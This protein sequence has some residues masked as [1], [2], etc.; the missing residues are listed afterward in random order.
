MKPIAVA[1]AAFGSYPGSVVVDFTSLA[2]RGL[3]VVTG[4]TGTGKSTIFDA[5]SFALFGKMPS[6]DGGD[7][8]SH[9]ATSSIDTFAKFT[10]EVDGVEY[11]AER[12]PSYLRPKK[13][14]HGATPQSASQLLTRRESDGSTTTLATK[15]REFDAHIDEII[16]LDAEQFRRVMLL[17]QGEVAR[18]L[19]DDS[20]QREELLSQLFG[21]A[22]YERVVKELKSTSD[23]LAQQVGTVDEQLRH[24]LANARDQLHELYTQLGVEAPELADHPRDGLDDVLAGVNSE[25]AQLDTDATQADNNATTAQRHSDEA[26]AAAHRFDDA[27]RHRTTLARLEADEPEVVAAASAAATSRSARPVVTAQARL[28]E[29]IASE[30]AAQ[31]DLNA[32]TE[33]IVDI[34]ASAGIE[35]GDLTAI[36]VSRQH[37]ALRSRLDIDRAALA[38][39]ADAATEANQ[40]VQAVLEN[41]RIQLET[42]ERMAAIAL[43]IETHEQRLAVLAELAPDTSAIDTE[44]ERL[45][46]A[47]TAIIERDAAASHRVAALAAATHADTEFDTTLERYVATEAPRLAERLTPGGPCMVCGSL[48]HPAPATADGGTVVSIDEVNSARE[49]R[50]AARHDADEADRR[51]AALTASLGDLAETS[52]GELD[53]RIADN[54]SEYAATN[55]AIAERRQLALRIEQLNKDLVDTTTA[56]HRAAG[57]QPGLIATRD[58]TA[59]AL[60]AAQAEADAIDVAQLEVVSRS[61]DE[62]EQLITGLDDLYTTLTSAQSRR[63]SAEGVLH[64]ALSKSPFESVDEATTA[65]IDEAA[66]HTALEQ[67]DALKQ[68][69]L[70]AQSALDTLAAAGIPD[71]RPD[72]TTLLERA[73]AAQE[74]ARSLAEQRT[75]VERSHASVET[76]LAE[77]DRIGESSSALRGRAD[78][79]RRAYA[80]CS[81]AVG[82]K[83]SLRRWVLGRELERVTQVASVHLASMTGS[84]Y[85]IQRSSTSGDG[86][87]SQGLDLEILD[88][89][90]GRP[91]RPNSLSGGE[92]FQASLALALGLA[93]VVSR[94]GTGSGRRIEA[95]FIDEGFGSLDPRALDDAI[96]T[97]HQLR[98]SGRMVGAITHV[99]AMKE[100]LHPGIVVSRRPDGKGSTLVVN[101]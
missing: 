83:I 90:T 14:G 11:T 2:A 69:R 46:M 27:A 87:T 16:G 55:A 25:R 35:I 96:E 65:L 9:H 36:G 82:N 75:I 81:G 70:S 78:A 84:R 13:T 31:H 54:R 45:I 32:R 66:E 88:A 86:R 44:H 63:E 4:D 91:R 23:Q 17:P 61:C 79:A 29:A 85:T 68:E 3:F 58:R 33:Q 51:L 59:A 30:G 101:P 60:E 74:H 57:A 39:A 8:R 19:L 40:A 48:E 26:T 72:V 20:K 38:A 42:G 37:A 18:F 1:F 49:R 99:E 6:K 47:R 56:S 53:L 43:D 7:I 92:Q 41:E 77:H 98:A 89:H 97:L 52:V 50:E 100:R 21:G 12:S 71:A 94:G 34:G 62:L 64:D 67:L 22:V 93:D 80:V 15:A 24:H 76:A 95:L 28:E 73:K 10:F 5:M